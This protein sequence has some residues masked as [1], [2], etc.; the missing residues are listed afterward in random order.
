MNKELLPKLKQKKE[1][2]KRWKQG[3]SDPAETQGHYELA[4]MGL[5]KIKQPRVESG[6]GT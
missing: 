3:Q 4:G 1:A 6:A 5:E 2:F